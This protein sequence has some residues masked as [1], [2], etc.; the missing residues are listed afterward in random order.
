MSALQLVLPGDLLD[1]TRLT[2]SELR[3]ELAVHLYEQSRLSLGKAA[4][5]A[6]YDPSR[7]MQLLGAREIA[8]HYDHAEYEADLAALQQFNES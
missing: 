6:Q 3:I 1:A 2:E 8:V 4:E 5:L 7:F